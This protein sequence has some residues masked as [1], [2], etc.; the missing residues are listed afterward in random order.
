MKKFIGLVCFISALLCAA[1]SLTAILF[2]YLGPQIDIQQL[3][4]YFTIAGWIASSAF[5]FV[6]IIGFSASAIPYV[7]DR[8]SRWEK[9]IAIGRLPWYMR[10][11]YILLIVAVFEFGFSSSGGVHLESGMWMKGASSVIVS[12][13]EAYELLSGGLRSRAA[14]CLL[15]S[16]LWMLFAY[17]AVRNQTEG[18][19]KT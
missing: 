6:F 17:G 15:L 5:V 7:R 4:N 9:R 13:S 10:L 18:D 8:V 12:R 14:M 3:L 2:T 16:L 19:G 1:V 11:C